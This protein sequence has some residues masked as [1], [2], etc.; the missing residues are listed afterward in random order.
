MSASSAALMG[1]RKLNKAFMPSNHYATWDWVADELVP[2]LG[3]VATQLEDP[4][5]E[6]K[7]NQGGDYITCLKL[8]V[9]VAVLTLALVLMGVWVRNLEKTITQLSQGLTVVLGKIKFCHTET[10]QPVNY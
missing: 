4:H 8:S 10:F 5:K 3:N 1:L 7:N 6:V 9:L 2:T